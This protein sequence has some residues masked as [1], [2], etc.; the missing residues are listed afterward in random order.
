MKKSMALIVSVMMVFLFV[1]AAHAQCAA[2]CK[3]AKACEKEMKATVTGTIEVKTEK[4]ADKEAKVPYVNVTECKCEKCPKECP[5]GK[6]AT[7]KIIGPK[8]ADAEKM[9]G[10]TVVMEGVCKACQEFE[11]TSITEKK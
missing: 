8:T 5:V 9:A 7:M 11:P 6:G 4:V 2:A 10:K 3:Q 1:G